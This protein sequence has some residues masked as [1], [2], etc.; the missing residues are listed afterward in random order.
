ML[1]RF[2]VNRRSSDDRTELDMSG[3]ASAEY[4]HS[5]AEFGDPLALPAAETWLLTRELPCGGGKDAIG[6][7]PLTCCTHW[8]NLSRDLA[9][10]PAEVVSVALVADPAARLPTGLLRDCF[11]D[12]CYHYKD[13]YFADLS[14]PL[15]TFVASHHQRNV[16]KAARSLRIECVKNP[17]NYLEIWN[18]LYTHLVERHAV[19]GIAAFSPTA[20]R[21]LMEVPGL[22]AY[23]A[24]AGEKIVG[25]LLW[26]IMNDKAYYH[27]AAYSERGYSLKAS[28]ALFWQS[29]ESLAAEKMAWAALGGGA[30]ALSAS[31]GLSRFKQG[32]S[33]ET[34]PA[35]FCGRILDRKRYAELVA[36]SGNPATSYFPAYRA[37]RLKDAA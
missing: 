23:V 36:L 17:A 37:P 21:R 12:V 19:R 3:Y 8:D 31:E 34:R 18:Q 5:L 9:E 20:F 29:L 33:T 22:R 13:H 26:L 1:S 27:L 35:Y 28:F 24:S 14:Q 4:A 6:C 11:P 25:M 10:L 7:Y 15:A 2:V 32:W 16:R 30:G